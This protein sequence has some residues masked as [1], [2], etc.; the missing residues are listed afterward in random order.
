MVAG[1]RASAPIGDTPRPEPLSASIVFP[2]PD[3]EPQ[4][5]V[6]LV[7]QAWA[8]SR[9]WR[10]VQRDARYDEVYAETEQTRKNAVAAAQIFDARAPPSRVP[11]RGGDSR[12]VRGAAGDGF[13]SRGRPGG[14][15][16]TCAATGLASNTGWACPSNAPDTPPP[17]YPIPPRLCRSCYPERRGW[18]PE[19]PTCLDGLQVGTTWPSASG[20][21]QCREVR[22]WQGVAHAT[23]DPGGVRAT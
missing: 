21:R 1:S 7:T 17:R 18:R 5:T 4:A 9:G 19:P 11:S 23:T 8:L 14:D 3:G 22:A 15:S 16:A 20:Y 10:R 12:R 13:L 6:W 2:W